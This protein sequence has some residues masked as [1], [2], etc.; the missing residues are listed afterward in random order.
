MKKI[1]LLLVLALS[2]VVTKSQTL[3]FLGSSNSFQSNSYLSN[4]PQLTYHSGTG[5]LHYSLTV[6][7]PSQDSLQTGEALG[8][9]QFYIWLNNYGVNSELV[10]INT[11]V[12]DQSLLPTGQVVY[13]GSVFIG[14]DFSEDV[15]LETAY[16]STFTFQG[17]DYRSNGGLDSYYF[18]N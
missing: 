12:M 14:N 7:Y 16:Y 15:L 10:G 6:N 4:P 1:F 5:M 2:F 18:T 8:G 3:A 17:N 9:V 13:S 11:E